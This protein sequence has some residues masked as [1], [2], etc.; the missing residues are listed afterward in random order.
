[1]IVNYNDIYNTH[2]KAISIKELF[3]LKI[4]TAN[5]KLLIKIHYD[6]VKLKV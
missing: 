5:G 2:P 6:K 1:M 4:V 3:F